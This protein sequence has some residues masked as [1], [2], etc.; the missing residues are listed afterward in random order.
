M[1]CIHTDVI[2]I[3]PDMIPGACKS[4]MPHSIYFPVFVL[5]LKQC[6]TFCHIRFYVHV[7]ADVTGRCHSHR[8]YS[9]SCDRTQSMVNGQTTRIGAIDGQNGVKK[10]VNVQIPVRNG[11][12]YSVVIRPKPVG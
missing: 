10:T 4:S 9:H 6:G 3:V 12:D 11:P 5:L 8:F 1:A 2:I 7:F